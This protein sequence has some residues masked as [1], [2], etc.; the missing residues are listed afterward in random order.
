[1]LKSKTALNH[2]A[3]TGNM[4][5]N[6]YTNIYTF[7]YNIFQPYCWPPQDDWQNVY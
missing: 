6:L 7:N 5:Y 3:E 4:I 1:M 2:V